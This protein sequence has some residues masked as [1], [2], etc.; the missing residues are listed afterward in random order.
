MFPVTCLISWLFGI[1]LSGYLGSNILVFILPSFL[2]VFWIG[3]NL[4]VSGITKRKIPLQKFLLKILILLAFSTCSAFLYQQY[5]ATH[6]EKAVSLCR[7]N[8][9]S[10]TGIVSGGGNKAVTAGERDEHDKCQSGG[11]NSFFQS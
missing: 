1:F 6:F 4:V 10:L 3:V 9:T 2:T 7:E 11:D 8:P 5:E